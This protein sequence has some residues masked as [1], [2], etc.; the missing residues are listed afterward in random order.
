MVRLQKG[1]RRWAASWWRRRWSPTSRPRPFALPSEIQTRPSRE[2]LL[3]VERRPEVRPHLEG[4]RGCGRKSFGSRWART[5]ILFPGSSTSLSISNLTFNPVLGA[6]ISLRLISF[7]SH[8][9]KFH[10]NV[11]LLSMCLYS[12]QSMHIVRLQGNTCLICLCR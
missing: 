7:L 5:P 8:K 9:Y 2:M 12:V 4:S 6:Q 11:L 3:S 10:R 1:M